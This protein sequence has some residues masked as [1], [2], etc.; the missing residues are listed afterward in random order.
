MGRVKV[1][2][3]AI[4]LAAGGMGRTGRY[5]DNLGICHIPC[6]SLYEFLLLPQIH[7][8]RQPIHQCDVR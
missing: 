3:D 5:S 1:G 4:L 2:A 6:G 8:Q 7:R